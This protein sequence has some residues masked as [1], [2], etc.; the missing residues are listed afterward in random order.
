MT[1]STTPSGSGNAQPNPTALARA[2]RT[3]LN[4]LFGAPEQPQAPSQPNPGGEVTGELRTARA[5]KGAVMISAITDAIAEHQYNEVKP[6]SKYS[7]NYVFQ[8]QQI[9]I[10]RT[11][12]NMA[13]VGDFERLRRD[14]RSQI[15][16]AQFKNFDGYDLS[17]FSGVRIEDEATCGTDPVFVFAG[18]GPLRMKIGVEIHGDFVEKA[19]ITAMPAAHVITPDTEPAT[20][21]APFI[22]TTA[23]SQT[24]TLYTPPPKPLPSRVPT[25]A[26]E[27]APA[28]VPALVLHI[29][30]PGHSPRSVSLTNGQFPARLGRGEDCTVVLQS[31]S[32]SRLH[33][34]LVQDSAM[35]AG[36]YRVADHS[37]AGTLLGSKALARDS[38]AV[39]THGVTLTL[40]P[41]APEGAITLRV[42]IPAAIAAATPVVAI[43][44]AIQA[45]TQTPTL[46]AEPTPTIPPTAP[47]YQAVARR[48]PTLLDRPEPTLHLH[49]LQP[50]PLVRL[51][52]RL[53]NGHSE[54]HDITDLPYEIGREPEADNNCFVADAHSKVSRQHLRITRPQAG[55]FLVQNLAYGTNGTWTGGER[56]SE[57][58]T[59]KAVASNAADGWCILGERSLS[60]LSAAIRLEQLA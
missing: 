28:A 30:E 48:T 14:Q 40:A 57:R 39:L 43:Q 9:C 15:I 35:G 24:A 31:P 5:P 36:H 4:I 51:R 1:T 26:P 32:V 44:E 6:Y 8:V 46:A 59:L 12:D 13:L 19:I 27:A 56:M 54:V 38:E 10:I 11:A 41:A 49:D 2:I 45:P 25:L 18:E 60:P 34:T 21:A 3:G 16:Q 37:L 55:A 29:S 23:P 20:A 50:Q 53:T 52:L 22:A 33:L 7:P 42:E 58:F 47:L 17:E